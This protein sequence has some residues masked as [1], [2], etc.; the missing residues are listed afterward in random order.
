MQRA[1]RGYA[2]DHRGHGR[3]ARTPAELGLFAERDGW[4]KGINDLWLLNRRI[5]TDHPGLPIVLLGH[6][7]GSFMTQ[8]FICEHGEALAAAV[9]SASNGKPQPIASRSCSPAWSDCGSGNAATAH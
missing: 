9:L 7:L 8:Y 1:L 4:T 6:S 5:A 3:T 2:D